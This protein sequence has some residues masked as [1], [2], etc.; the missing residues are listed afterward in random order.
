M[1]TNRKL[2]RNALIADDSSAQP[3]KLTGRAY[4]G[5]AS[6][7]LAAVLLFMV[8]N[9]RQCAAQIPVVRSIKLVRERYTIRYKIGSGRTFPQTSRNIP[10]NS[11]GL[12]GRSPSDL[13]V[14]APLGP[15]V[16]SP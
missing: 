1:S 11:F 4:C 14:P 12:F 10:C 9:N 5:L 15:L 6:R 3:I 8:A 2:A 16:S 7:L 13:S